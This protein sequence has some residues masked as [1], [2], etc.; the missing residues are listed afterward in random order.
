[1]AIL[2]EITSKADLQAHKASI[3]PSTLLVVYY[4]D[5]ANDSCKEMTSAIAEIAAQ[6]ES[7]EA[8]QVLSIASIDV[9]ATRNATE[10]SEKYGIST[11]PYTVFLRD[12]KLRQ[13]ITGSDPE[14]LRDAI[15]DQL[16]AAAQ[17]PPPKPAPTNPGATVIPPDQ[18]QNEPLHI[19]LTKLTRLALVVVFL[20]GTP[21]SPACRF[22]RRMV[23]LLDEHGVS[24]A[25]FNI[26]AD[27]KVRQGL[28]EF[29]DWPT[30]PQLWINGELAGGLDVVSFRV[31]RASSHQM[32]NGNRFETRLIRI[33]CS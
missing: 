29:S 17:P 31:V 24:Y 16:A 19:R 15:T 4:H 8:P 6:N 27:D 30:F 26:L 20:K 7:K 12:R 13:A 1:M 32:L 18:F 9:N 28:K 3:S 11:I 21:Q 14:Q 23:T 2:A 5:T 10:S 25:G 33:P 22:S